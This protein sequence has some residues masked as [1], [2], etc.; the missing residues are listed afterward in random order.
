VRTY[1]YQS[2]TLTS[3]TNGESESKPVS[4]PF[5]PVRAGLTTTQRTNK[6]HQ[7]SELLNYLEKQVEILENKS[8]KVLSISLTDTTHL[9][10]PKPFTIDETGTD[11]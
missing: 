10:E 7:L 1:V 5:G 9:V 11:V 6:V 3:Y 2:V 8:S 4:S